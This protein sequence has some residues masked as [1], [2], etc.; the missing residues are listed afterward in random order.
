[1]RHTRRRALVLA[2]SASAGAAAMY[3]TGS[4]GAPANPDVPNPD[5][6]GE[7]Q[8]FVDGELV[9]R[10]AGSAKSDVRIAL[11]PSARVIRVGPATL[12]DFERG[13]VIVA[14][15]QW[16]GER[17][18]ADIVEPTLRHTEGVVARRTSRSLELR[19]GRAIRLSP[20]TR[21]R[22]DG[23]RVQPSS[24]QASA[25]DRVAGLVVGNFRATTLSA[26]AL[27]VE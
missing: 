1:M 20:N 3:A 25:G 10:P 21:A 4:S 6:W 17:L 8:A 13:D 26:D 12:A 16:I 27:G 5:L 9:V 2:T 19:D 22:S 18:L 7:V 24:A 15:G 14:F 23:N 11:A